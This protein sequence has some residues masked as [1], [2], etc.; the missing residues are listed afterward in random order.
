MVCD[1][2]KRV[3]GVT[4]TWEDGWYEYYVFFMFKDRRVKGLLHREKLE[5]SIWRRVIEFIEPCKP[6][7]AVQKRVLLK[8]VLQ[9]I[10][11][12]LFPFLDLWQR[13]K[14]WKG[15]SCILTLIHDFYFISAS[16]AAFQFLYLKLPKA[17]NS[18]C[19]KSIY[20]IYCSINHRKLPLPWP[21]QSKCHKGCK[22][23]SK[24]FHSVNALNASVFRI[25]WRKLPLPWTIQS[26]C[27]IFVEVFFTASNSCAYD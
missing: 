17:I 14:I 10:Y 4:R 5:K 3:G 1:V 18:Y 25:N 9:Y 20:M 12:I 23:I 6:G 19:N 21:I 27:T 22:S 7:R 11:I 16:V 2:R 8:R 24:Y 26:S 13:R 15:V